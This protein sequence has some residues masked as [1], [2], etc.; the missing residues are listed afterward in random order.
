MS[1]YTVMHCFIFLRIRAIDRVR[2]KLLAGTLVLG[3]SALPFHCAYAIDDAALPSGG[4]VVGGSATLDYGDARLDVYQG[5]DRLIIDWDS[6]NIG[7]NATTQFH[8]PGSG[9][10]AVNRVTGGIDPTMILGR[11]IANGQVIVLDPNGVIFGHDSV[12]D[13]G[14]IIASTGKINDHA[15]MGGSPTLEI[16]GADTG[17]AIINHGSITV[18]QAGIAAFVAP[19]IQNSGVIKAKLGKISLASGDTATLDL[20]GDGLVEIAVDGAAGKALIENTGTLS[21]EGGTVL[22]SAKAAGDAVNGLVNLDGVVNVSSVSAV[23]GK[24]VV[25]GGNINVADTGMLDASGTQGGSVELCAD[26]KTYVAGSI[27]ASGGNGGFIETSAIDT[28]DIADTAAIDTG[29]GTWLIDP[30]DFTIA[31]SGG[32]ITTAAL[33]AQLAA[34]NITIETASAGAD[35]GDIFVN[36]ALNWTGANTL[37]LSAH[38]NISVNQAITNTTG[39]SLLLRADKEGSGTG[40]VTFGGSGSVTLSGGGR[41]DLYYNPTAYTTATD[42]SGNITGT[43]TA[44]ML[45]NNVNQLQ[46]MNTNLAGAYAL[47]KDIDASDTATWNAGAGFAP[48]GDNSTSSN[49]SR[50]RGSLDGLG[51]TITGLTIDRSATDYVGLFGYTSGPTI[52]NVGLV[53]GSIIGS[54]YVGGLVGQIISGGTITNNYVTATVSGVGRVGGLVGGNNGGTITGSYAIGAVTG[55]GEY[56]GGLAG[57]SSS[58]GTIT[59][60]YATG[61]VIG[62]SQIGGLVG[63]NA[64]SVA[65]SYATGTVSGSGSNIGGLVGLGDGG[66]TATGSHATGAVSGSGNYVGGLIGNSSGAVISSYAMGAVSGDSIV[67][68]LLG[69]NGGAVSGSYATGTVSGSGSVGGLVGGNVGGSS[70]TSS[71]ATGAVSGSGDYVG[72][73]TGSNSSTATIASSYATGTVAGGGNVG[74]LTG[75]NGGA[76]TNTYSTGTVSG[77]ANYVGGLAG[78]NVS[79]GTITSSYSTGAVIGSGNVGGLVGGNGGAVSIS[80][81]NTE[82]SGRAT[83]A[84]GTGLTAAEM[85]QTASFS[86]WSI[87]DSAGTGTTWRIYEGDTYPL[88]ASFLT[89]LTV[90]ADDISV[91]YVTSPWSGGAVS[92]AGFKTGN[93][94]SDLLGTLIYGGSSQGAMAPASYTISLLGGLY[95]GQQ[96]YDIEYSD[97]IGIL[98]IQTSPGL[99]TKAKSM[100]RLEVSGARSP[101]PTADSTDRINTEHNGCLAAFQ[102][103]CIIPQETYTD[104]IC[105]YTTHVASDIYQ[106]CL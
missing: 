37:T 21:A 85:M 23:G 24:I 28:V 15:F 10:I 77:S 45:V 80:Y 31:D 75:S 49:A 1:Q 70:V 51:H 76:V 30:T 83:S 6:F 73:L 91:A 86:G 55:T 34:N 100:G 29:G 14:G 71:Y 36:D 103:I 56:V 74:G 9:S 106:Q 42:Y 84:G 81:W 4:S 22:M 11:L 19:T 5:T 38:R 87:R 62:E 59:N 68:G 48:I 94:V 105:G 18:A 67:G 54:S 35:A 50:F 26:A 44:W 40:T 61:M 79:T 7:K 82:T 89:S 8:Q 12:I 72:G 63:G 58:G 16:T 27:F 32:N 92:Y 25:N 13:V 47:G 43:Y 104:N 46:A 66:S 69:S 93:D 39:G 65:S 98:T 41:A 64:G 78:R 60:S 95:S 97:R 96:G 99:I 3:V 57:W 90:S 33:A 102:G 17:G 20:Y 53:G 2:G 52:R 88:L 101:P